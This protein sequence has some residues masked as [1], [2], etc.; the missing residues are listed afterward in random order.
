MT[1]APTLDAARDR[2]AAITAAARAWRHGLDAM[3]RMPVAA[4][5]RACHEPGGPSLAELEAR[6]TADRAARTRAH[7][8]AA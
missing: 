8:A 6:I 3:D 2:A 7:R 1:T 5:A 4:A